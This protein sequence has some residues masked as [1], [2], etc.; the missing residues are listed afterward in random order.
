MQKLKQLFTYSIF[1]VL[2]FSAQAQAN[3]IVINKN[4]LFYPTFSINEA[5][6][7][8]DSEKLPFG[9]NIKEGRY[10]LTW[11][12]KELN[13]M[14]TEDYAQDFIDKNLEDINTRHKYNTPLEDGDVRYDII[15]ARRD[16][17]ALNVIPISYDIPMVFEYK[18]PI[19]GDTKQYRPKQLGLDIEV[20]IN[21]DSLSM[22]KKIPIHYLNKTQK[23]V[24]KDKLISEDYFRT[25]YIDA[26]GAIAF[27]FQ[28]IPEEQ[29]YYQR[30]QENPIQEYLDVDENNINGQL[31]R[32]EGR[33]LSRKSDDG[34]T[35]TTEVSY[36]TDF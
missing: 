3:D 32:P 1:S 4:S 6:S 22:E 26:F 10:F 18:D 31:P 14:L 28:V 27:A 17:V 23:E 34:N 20:S 36:L 13:A 7:Q 25:Q 9:I 5:L 15:Y 21:G 16:P 24:L 33:S 8:E 2:A 35:Y 11:E 12:S 29:E 19:S 30:K